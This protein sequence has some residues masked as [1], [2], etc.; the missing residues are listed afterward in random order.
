MRRASVPAP[1]RP[2]RK[3]RALSINTPTGSGARSA[4][5]DRID[6]KRGMARQLADPLARHVDL[7]LCRDAAH[8]T[9]KIV[10]KIGVVHQHHVGPLRAIPRIGEVMEDSIE[11]V[12]SD[13]SADI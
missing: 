2:A 13:L 12:E 8:L 10:N 5:R 3:K 9:R 1:E 11:R 7:E 4:P 6:L